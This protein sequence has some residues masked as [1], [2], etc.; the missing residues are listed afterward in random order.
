MTFPRFNPQSLLVLAASLLWP[1]LGGCNPNGYADLWEAN[2]IAIECDGTTTTWIRNYYEP[3]MPIGTDEETQ[4][5]LRTEFLIVR[6]EI[7]PLTGVPGFIETGCMNLSTI[8]RDGTLD[9]LEGNFLADGLGGGTWE[10]P[11][12]YEFVHE[13]GARILDREGSQTFELDPHEIHNVAM[14]ASAGDLT[15]SV[16]GDE[17]HYRNLMDVIAGI[18]K[19]QTGATIMGQLLNVGLL[20]SQAR[21]RGFGG[22]GMTEYI[23]TPKDFR[24]L[25]AGSIHVS[26]SIGA[27]NV[28]M[29]VDYREFSDFTGMSLSGPQ[30]V[31][32]SWAGNGNMKGASDFVIQLDPRDPSQTLVGRFDYDGVTIMDGFGDG[33]AGTLTL[34]GV[35]YVVITNEVLITDLRSIL[36]IE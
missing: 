20:V 12:M 19:D 8:H 24:G 25:I 3:G 18:P 28:N 32:V 9:L 21:V 22:A 2:D 15:L 14:T 29:T 17:L 10:I 31:D 1:V 6:S 4:T 27:G 13:T 30:I 16:D 5:A 35:D 26:G 23:Q 36:L 7:D 11:Q 33:G 34:N